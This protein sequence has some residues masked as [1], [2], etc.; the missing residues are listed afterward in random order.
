MYLID[1]NFVIHLI[2]KEA[3]LQISIR[4]KNCRKKD[5]NWF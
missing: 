4:R 3:Y 5:Q 2:K 1:I